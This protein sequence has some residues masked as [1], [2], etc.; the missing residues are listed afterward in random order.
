MVGRGL[1]WRVFGGNLKSPTYLIGW[2]V[3]LLKHWATVILTS[4]VLNN[5]NLNF[6][7]TGQWSVELSKH[8]EMVNLT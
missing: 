2:P 7:S 4:E 1:T 8:W 3:E 6:L 5:G